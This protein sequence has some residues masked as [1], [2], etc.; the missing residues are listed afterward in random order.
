MPH[1]VVREEVT[2][3]AHV[4]SVLASLG[5]ARTP[6]E[7]PVLE[8]L[9]RL[10]ES[11][12]QRQSNAEDLPALLDQIHHQTSLLQ[13]LRSA[14][15]APTVD[16][17]SPYFAHLR[18]RENERERDL[19]LGRATC[20]DKGLRIIDWRDAPLSK[21]FYRYQQGDE[22]EEEIAGRTREGEVVVKRMVRI[23]D[24]V[25]DR[26][27]APE[28]D[29]SLD[30]DSPS[31]WRLVRADRAR[32]AGGESAAMRAYGLGEGWDRRLGSDLAGRLQRADKRLPEI[33][34]LIDPEQFELITRP[35]SGYVVIRGTAGS[36]KTTVALH[37][38]A[39]LAFDDPSIDS[40][41][42]LIV[43]FSSALQRY[44]GHLLPALGLDHVRIQTFETWAR[45]E[46]ARHFPKLPDVHRHDA[47]ALAQR[48][49][50]HP[51]MA[52]ALE[53]QVARIEA[54]EGGFEALREQAFDDWASVLTQER[55]LVETFE[56]EAP[57]AFTREEIGSFVHRNRR[58]LEEVN[59]FVAG[60]R[61]GDA[62]LDPEDD[63]LLLRAWQLRVGPL[64]RG[65][66]KAVRYRHIVVDEVQDFTP[67][68]VRVLVDCLDEHQ[69]LT[70]AGDTQ[71]HLS[72]HSGFTS[73]TSFLERLGLPG[74]EVETLRISYR[75]SAE[76]VSFAL[77]LLGDLREDEEPPRA[78]RH[79]PPV[80][81]FRFDDY[82]SCAA[83]L[84]DALR[85]L[86][87]AEPL[88]SVAVLTPS[89]DASVRTYEALRRGGL[90]QLRLVVDQDFSFTQG[91]E[92][93]EIEQVKGLEFDYVVLVD[94][95]AT[96]YP[97][98]PRARRR[99][100]VGA[101]RAIHQLWLTSV[102]TPSPLL[103]GL[104]TGP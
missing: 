50:L 82:G 20:I 54:P 2:L 56:R 83:F 87:L 35:S 38:V 104:A 36:G 93:T 79:G 100:H 88:A 30:P 11:I 49:K 69:S 40:E 94:V 24:G 91:V 55:L 8:E 6:S 3:Y 78:A 41:A 72:E 13:Q 80:E 42:T 68:E 96:Q 85:E 44:V 51:A 15:E 59:A 17:R 75:S 23:R 86:A 28:G 47:P 98:L 74:H 14:R 1:D 26:I 99:L 53:A 70:L 39:Y 89:S 31:G 18:L 16:P 103:A 63:A 81:L 95:T 48:L 58:R 27:Q 102:G 43:V 97:D 4:A 64:Q 77:G 7:K 60:E 66:R 9:Q 73:W 33:T 65:G 34:G 29:F 12:L 32:L 101:T 61:D 21:I 76:I 45:A 92:V 90:D 67:L 25:L 10:R 62:A 52:R 22:F 71:Q 19:C 57:G 46:R 5:K 84:V 37:R